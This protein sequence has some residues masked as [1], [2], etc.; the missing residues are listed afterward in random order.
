MKKKIKR[1]SFYKNKKIY[2]TDDIDVNNI[3]VSKKES[4]STKNSLK[5]FIGYNGNDYIRPL[6]IRLPQ[7]TGYARKFDEN[8]TMYFIVK[9]KQHLKNYT[10]IRETIEKLM[11]INFESK[12]VYGDHDK[13]I[14]TKIKMYAGSIIT[15]FYNKKMPKEK[16]P[17][18]CLSIIMID[19]VINV[20]KKYYPQTLLEQCKY[21]QE[22]IKIVNHIDEDLVDSE[23]D[24]SSNDE[25]ESDIDNKE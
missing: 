4:Y 11:K 23:S 22:K 6:C 3:L 25:T 19:S 24:D 2:S 14:K 16:A 15:N 20:N 10:K 5:Y 7:M 21:I 9:D 8:A 17:C 12:P 1:S 13:Y 18:K